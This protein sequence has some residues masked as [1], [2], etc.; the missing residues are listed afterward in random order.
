VDRGVRGA[1]VLLKSTSRNFR[2]RPKAES[3]REPTGKATRF[4]L[5]AHRISRARAGRQVIGVAS[6]R[7]PG[8][9]RNA[10]RERGSPRNAIRVYGQRGAGREAIARNGSL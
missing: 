5:L 4:Q 8:G 3:T 1:E 10:I 2:R 6:I 9:V 7:D